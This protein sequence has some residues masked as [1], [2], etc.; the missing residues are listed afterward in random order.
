[1]DIPVIIPNTD[2]QLKML[3]DLD[4]RGVLATWY[5]DPLGSRREVEGEEG[6]DEE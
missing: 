4:A 1:M 5:D 6:E 2:E 3:K